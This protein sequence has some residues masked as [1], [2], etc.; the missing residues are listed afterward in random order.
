MDTNS[1]VKLNPLTPEQIA[2]VKQQPV[3]GRPSVTQLGATLAAAGLKPL[4]LEI[5][6]DGKTIDFNL[7]RT[8][9]VRGLDKEQT[10]RRLVTIFRASGFDVGFSE[11]GI[12]DFDE[13]TLSG[14]TLC[15]PVDRICEQGGI[16]INP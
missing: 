2:W 9:A 1:T 10:L 5:F 13:Q 14:S 16:K 6:D 4:R 12:G 7:A 3:V 11:L 15:G 8:E